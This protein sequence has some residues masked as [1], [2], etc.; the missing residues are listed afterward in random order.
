MPET[1]SLLNAFR[2]DNPDDLSEAVKNEHS[3]LRVV[4]QTMK[5]WEDFLEDYRRH[6][7][8]AD[9]NDSVLLEILNAK[10]LH[11]HKRT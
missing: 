1:A 4:S 10:W 3:L 5:L 8:T 6:N 7:P 2:L 11:E 9:L